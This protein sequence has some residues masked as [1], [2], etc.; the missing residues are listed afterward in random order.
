MLARQNERAVRAAL[1]ATRADLLQS[2][3]IDAGIIGFLGA[4]LGLAL[5]IPLVWLIVA[6][7]PPA[8]E[9]LEVVHADLGAG[10]VAG[11]LGIVVTLLAGMLPAWRGS[12]AAPAELLHGSWAAGRPEGRRLREVLLVTEVGLSLLLLVGAGLVTRSLWRLGQL[13]VGFQPSGLVSASLE[14]P[15]WRYQTPATREAFLR[16]VTDAVRSLAGI[17]AA[18]RASGVPPEVGVSFGELGI[19]GRDL[20][21]NER[22]SFFAYQSVESG[23]FLTMGIPLLAGSTF[24]PGASS[25]GEGALIVSN[26]LARRYW[27]AGDAVGHQVRVSP[28]SPWQR[29]VGV[30]AD[31]PGLGLGELRGAMHI[32]APISA[33]GDETNIIARTA[34]PLADFETALRQVINRFDSN[35]P[36]RRIAALPAMLRESTATERFTGVLLSGFAAFATVLFAAGLFGVLSHAVS[37]R[38]REIGVRIAIGADP[39][40]V[41][42]LVVWQG[43]RPVL[44]GIVLGLFGAWMG[45]K[46]LAALLFDITPRDL[47]TFAAAAAVTILV[48][49]AASYVPARR[50][51]R[52]DPVSSLRAE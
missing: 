2:V 42:W 50:A 10:L 45:G 38:T 13:D 18:T 28:G 33:E 6:N 43:M 39:R 15:A 14:L 46:T 16:E 49:L 22:E 40:Q 4:G 21:E 34:L 27:P 20:G 26:R 7:R 47:L 5:S 11:L 35:V 36:I 41:R 30:A 44:I 24:D 1:G 31:V 9:M 12:R 8:L 23:Y 29:I 32:Y 19:A 25:G 52:L 51:S 3:L 37:Q 48:A 17:E